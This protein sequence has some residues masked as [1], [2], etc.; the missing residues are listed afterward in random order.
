M[1]NGRLRSAE[2]TPEK[3]EQAKKMRADNASWSDI[4]S[5]TGVSVYIL[6]CAVLPDF[7]RQQ[8]ERVRQHRA[9]RVNGR[10]P[11]SAYERKGPKPK[12]SILVG[13][14]GRFFGHHAIGDYGDHGIVIPNHVIMARERA[15]G[16][17]HKDLT[18]ALLGDPPPWRSALGKKNGWL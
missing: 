8:A 4:T 3:L 16:F 9:R 18:A 1:W 2:L 7:R 14:D 17:Y 10:V 12:N 5:V 11:H 15:A 13:S 6:K